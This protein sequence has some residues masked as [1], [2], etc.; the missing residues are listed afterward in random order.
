M[1]SAERKYPKY[2]QHLHTESERDPVCGMEVDPHSHG[3]ATYLGRIYH[4][5]SG[6]CQAAFQREPEKYVQTP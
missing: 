2:G 4:F 5:C 3:E 6:D 1:M